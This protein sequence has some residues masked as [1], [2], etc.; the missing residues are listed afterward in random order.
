MHELSLWVVHLVTL[1]KIECYD[2]GSHL[3]QSHHCGF[4]EFESRSKPQ[5]MFTWKSVIFSSATV[6]AVIVGAC[7]LVRESMRDGEPSSVVVEV[8]ELLPG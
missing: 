1:R 3:E 2:L 8:R 6:A 5:R 7:V 4:V